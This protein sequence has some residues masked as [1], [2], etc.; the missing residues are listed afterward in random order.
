MA[1]VFIALWMPASATS[2]FAGRI[3]SLAPILRK[4]TPGAINIS[5]R[6]RVKEDNPLYQD[7]VF[8]F[9]DLPKQL[10][11]EATGSGVI[12]DAERRCAHQ[13]SRGRTRVGSPDNEQGAPSA[14]SARKFTVS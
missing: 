14:A 3:P 1:I 6:G 8:R 2:E 12:V 5:V 7:P 4:I 13:Q 9:F 11:R 10:E